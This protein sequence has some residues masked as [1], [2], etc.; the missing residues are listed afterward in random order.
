MLVEGIVLGVACCIYAA[1]VMDM[2]DVEME[3]EKHN[4]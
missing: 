2:E 1:A 3:R 4:K